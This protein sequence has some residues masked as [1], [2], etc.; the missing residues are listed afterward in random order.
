VTPPTATY[1]PTQPDS[2]DPLPT[3]NKKKRTNVH[4]NSRRRR[5][6]TINLTWRV[7][8]PLFKVLSFPFVQMQKSHF[9]TRVCTRR[10]LALLSLS[11]SLCVSLFSLSLSPCVQRLL[12]SR[13]PS[14]RIEGVV[15]KRVFSP[16]VLVGYFFT[17]TM[18]VFTRIF[19]EV[20]QASFC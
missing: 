18:A 1:P 13:F 20:F 16:I 17:R 6:F 9:S 12:R 7:T 5:F 19:L 8:W 3:K 4:N 15:N 14:S 2:S 10:S 11:V